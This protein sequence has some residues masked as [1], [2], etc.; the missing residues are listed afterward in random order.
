MA[1]IL[2]GTLGSYIIL[3]LILLAYRETKHRV[4]SI[5][6]AGALSLVAITLTAGLRAPRWR[7]EPGLS[8][9]VRDVSSLHRA[10]GTDPALPDPETPGVLKRARGRY[11]PAAKRDR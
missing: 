8:G 6:Q 10:R 7:T 2:S 4:R 1:Q 9:S 11:R 5:L 3:H